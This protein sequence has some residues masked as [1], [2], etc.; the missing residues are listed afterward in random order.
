MEYKN[1]IQLEKFSLRYKYFCFIDTQE[2]LADSLFI[3]HKVRVWFQNEAHNPNTEFIIIFCK[4]KKDDA[5]RF[6]EALEE[7]NNKM[8]LLG[9]PDYENF[10]KEFYDNLLEK[11][12]KMW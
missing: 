2:Y 5:D 3:K 9:H 1:F 8:T 11:K 6:A 7:L 10:C 4:V 12:G